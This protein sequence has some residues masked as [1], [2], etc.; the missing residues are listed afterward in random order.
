MGKLVATDTFLPITQ[1]TN[2]E[3]KHLQSIAVKYA[4]KLYSP[5]Y[6]D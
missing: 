4:N 3:L 6:L 5:D 2:K 1:M